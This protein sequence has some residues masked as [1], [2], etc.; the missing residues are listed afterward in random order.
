MTADTVTVKTLRGLEPLS[1]LSA[2]RLTELAELCVVERIS[3]TLDPFRVK[4]VAGQLVF[5]LRGELAL[6]LGNGSSE[7]VGG[8]DLGGAPPARA[9][10]PVRLRQG[11][12]RHRA[13]PASTRTC[14]T[15]W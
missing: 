1:A 4:G 5:L 2:H 9:E 11:D 10:D 6:I 8:R 13:R 14:S 3:K 15:S 12:H 7:V